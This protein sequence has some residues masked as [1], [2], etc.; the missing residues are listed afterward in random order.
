MFP[1]I[2]DPVEGLGFFLPPSLV[3]KCEQWCLSRSGNHVS[4]SWLA[5]QACLKG[6][7]Y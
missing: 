1:T 7:M 3:K 4:G 5:Q 2:I 6:G